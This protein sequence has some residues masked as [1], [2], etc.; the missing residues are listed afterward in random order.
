M[1]RETRPA[2][3]LK[4]PGPVNESDAHGKD[5]NCCVHVL[6]PALMDVERNALFWS[7][8]RFISYLLS[9]GLPAVLSILQIKKVTNLF[10]YFCFSQL[11]MGDEGHAQIVF[12]QVKLVYFVSTHFSSSFL[13]NYVP[14]FVFPRCQ[15]FASQRRRN[16]QLAGLFSNPSQSFLRP[17]P[18][19]WESIV[20]VRFPAAQAAPSN[21]I[22]V[23]QYQSF[24][25][26]SFSI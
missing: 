5:S 1:A 17:C 3:R 2:S 7:I 13:A 9:D 6:L 19:H 12:V 4:H 15:L 14:P 24:R 26:D 25:I 16:L 22:F 21:C 8:V 18:R 10:C 20:L 23:D 11:W